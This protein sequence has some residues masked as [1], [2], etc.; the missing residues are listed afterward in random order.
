ML[1]LRRTRAGRGRH[2]EA[3]PSVWPFLVATRGGGSGLG[4][5]RAAML[6][7]KRLAA[8]VFVGGTSGV[9][10]EFKVAGNRADVPRFAVGS[11]VGRPRPCSSMMPP[12]PWG[13]PDP[14]GPAS[15]RRL[16][17]GTCRR[18][19]SRRSWRPSQ[20]GSRNPSRRSVSPWQAAPRR[21]S[22]TPPSTYSVAS[23]S[24][25][26]WSPTS[27]RACGGSRRCSTTHATWGSLSST[28]WRPCS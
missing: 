24:W 13:P 6:T 4:R 15:R 18:E 3:P 19:P 12:L 23:P 21:P 25:G 20:G 26:W 1:F 7:S 27:S 9:V 11:V 2:R 28:R 16:P 8:S 5:M 14:V 22:A 17:S 10:E